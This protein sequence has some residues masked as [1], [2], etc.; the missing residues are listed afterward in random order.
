MSSERF[1][2]FRKADVVSMCHDVLINKE[3]A[4]ADSTANS[5]EVFC[6][7]LVSR[8]HFQYHEQLE[9]LKNS[10]ALFDPNKDTRTLKDITDSER[11]A[12]QKDFASEFSTLLDSA[13]FEKV[14]DSDLEDAL[15]EE[16]LF[17]VRLAVSFDDFQEVVFYRRGES[18]KTETLRTFFGLRKKSISFTNYDRVAVY[19]TFKDKDYFEQRKGT[20]KQLPVT[21]TP[22][23]TIIKLFQNVPKAD[24]EMLFPNSE[25]KMRP[26]DKLIIGASATVGGIVVLV[27]K[28]GASILLLSSFLAFWLGLKDESVELTKQSLI[29]FGIGMGVFGSFVFKEWTKFKNRKIRFM[30]A[31]SDNLYF[32]N[33]DNNAGVFHTLVDAAEEEDC[34][35]ALLAYTFLLKH[36]GAG[37]SADE[38][39]KEIEAWFK[40]THHCTLDFDVSDAI[41]KLVTMKLVEMKPKETGLVETGRVDTKLEDKNNERFTAKPLKSAINE[42][43]EY[44]DNIYQG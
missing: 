7:L 6:N 42:L 4:D 10:Y 17:K 41:D 18:V 24:L 13:N 37:M 3:T 14:T 31:L 1:I 34:K 32:K 38:L 33:L 36:E 30:K 26:L 44:W 28:L 25:V 40:H 20:K 5:F 39:D 11:K 16:S 29:T 2:P 8:I 23:A 12:V 22:G 15:H 9:R 19:I 27:T 21:F 35:E 43:D